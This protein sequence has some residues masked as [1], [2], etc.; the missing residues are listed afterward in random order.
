MKVEFE[1]INV[2]YGTGYSIFG[3]IKGG[4]E[5]HR[6]IL[7]RRARDGWHYAGFVPVIQRS[8][9][10]VEEIDLVFERE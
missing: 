4:T 3:G 6:E 9:G 8:T 7:V 1:R 10:Y 5:E 2:D